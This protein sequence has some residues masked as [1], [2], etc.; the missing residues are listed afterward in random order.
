MTEELRD[1]FRASGL[2][3]LLAVS[4]QNVLFIALGSPA[5]LAAR[6]A[7]VTARAQD[8]RRDRCSTCSRSGGSR[9]SCAPA[10]PGSLRRWRG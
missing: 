3:H 4:G 5:W 6:G 2:Y 7:A 10:S 8:R 1:D 9:P